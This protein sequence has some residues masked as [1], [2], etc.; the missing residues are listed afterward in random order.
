MARGVAIVA[1]ACCL[2]ACRGGDPSVEVGSR[3]FAIPAIHAAARGPLAYTPTEADEALLAA[4][5]EKLADGSPI[6]AE[7]AA[8]SALFDESS[9]PKEFDRVAV[10]VYQP[11]RR[12]ILV[13]RR[14]SGWPGLAASL[15]RIR[16]HRRYREFDFTDAESCRIQLDFIEKAPTAVDLD[17]LEQGG[18]GAKRFE[19]GVDGFRLAWAD[20]A[21]YFLP[22]DAFVRSVHSDGQLRRYLKRLLSGADLEEVRATRFVSESYVSFGDSWVRLFRGIPVQGPADRG[23]VERT[24][25]RAIANV[26]A[27]MH[28]DGRFR[29]YYDTAKDS[30]RDREHPKRD[31]ERNPYYN[32]L[33]HSG[34]GLLL[35]FEYRRTK[36]PQV[37]AALQHALE[38]LTAQIVPY[39]LPG[40]RPAGYVFYN[41]KAKL[42]GSGIALALLSEYQRDTGDATYQPFAERLKNH[43]LSEVSPSG[44][45]RYYKVYL[46]EEVEWSDNRS[47]FSFYYPGEAILG[48]ADYHNYVASEP[49]KLEIREVMARALRFLL[50]ARP[51]VHHSHYTALPADSW[52]MMGINEAWNVPE[53]QDPA[54]ADFVFDDA[55]TMVDQMYTT[56]D[57]LYPDYPGTFY[58]DYGD[59]PYADGARAEGLLAAL[60]LAAKVGDAER[61]QRYATAARQL[62]WATMHLANSPEALYFAARPDL[63]HGA[64]RFKHTRQWFRIDT[65]QH[66]AGFYLKLLPNWPL[67]D[68]D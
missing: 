1:L 68:R 28:E 36:S 34:G 62:A 15:D 20:Q 47:F 4:I 54:Y 31:P 67:L 51:I 32:I 8:F 55:D 48:L 11:G 45:F 52:L 2:V 5:R 33:R 59:Y 29:Y 65:T 40:D 19:P 10:V 7:D 24:A 12:R 66:V 21:R 23:D 42:G 58:Y 26:L 43:L 57:A 17:R 63:A 41:R 56:S 30:Y 53:L 46:D 9:F 60:E 39:E 14:N 50:K 38:F 64:I 35:L 25:T 44:E 49:E 61:T 6:S 27:N 3:G 18:E 22:G 13:V 16:Q 37:L